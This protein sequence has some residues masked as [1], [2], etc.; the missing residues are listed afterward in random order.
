MPQQSRGRQRAVAAAKGAL[1]APG[2]A[3]SLRPPAPRSGCRP[4]VFGCLT[5]FNCL[6]YWI[7][8]LFRPFL[9]PLF[10]YAYLTVSS[11]LLDKYWRGAEKL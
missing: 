7:M 5:G 10:C 3:A 8:V 6:F 11:I 9:L 4:P 1:T 2:C